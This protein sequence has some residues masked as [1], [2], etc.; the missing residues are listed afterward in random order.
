MEF[1]LDPRPDP[2][3]LPLDMGCTLDLGALGPTGGVEG[4][5]GARL[6]FDPTRMPIGD[7]GGSCERVF[8]N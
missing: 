7:L 2:A 3:P 4:G 5:I 6:E 8:D 1:F